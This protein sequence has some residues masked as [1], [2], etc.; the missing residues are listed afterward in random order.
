MTKTE[1]LISVGG[2]PD[3]VVIFLCYLLKIIFID[4]LVHLFPLPVDFRLLLLV[5][6]PELFFL[7]QQDH[8]QLAILF[9]GFPVFVTSPGVIF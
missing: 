9:I 7:N 8:R 1:G 5:Y 6:C 3:L 4:E 2:N